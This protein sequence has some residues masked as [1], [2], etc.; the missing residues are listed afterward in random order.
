[1]Q[2]LAEICRTPLALSEPEVGEATLA[3][4]AITSELSRAPTRQAPRISREQWGDAL[5]KAREAVEK[6]RA[7]TERA[8]AM[9]ARAASMTLAASQM[10]Q[11][12]APPLAPIVRAWTSE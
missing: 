4:T 7:A 1:M 5:R 3:L 9:R 10:R 11:R 2:E 8:R 6:A 12:V